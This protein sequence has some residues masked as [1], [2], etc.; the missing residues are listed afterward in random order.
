MSG[1][2]KE[3]TDEKPE[4][5]VPT[6]GVRPS[7]WSMV[8]AYKPDPE[9]KVVIQQCVQDAGKAAAYAAVPTLF[10]SAF[11][12]SKTSMSRLGKLLSTLTLTTAAA[13]VGASATVGNAYRRILHLPNTSRLKNELGCIV[14]EWNP[15]YADHRALKAYKAG[16]LGKK[17]SESEG[18]T[19]KE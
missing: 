1:T 15:A 13:Y 19:A 11:L 6:L 8:K 4:Q 7:V 9:E 14:F 17:H 3:P 16:E 10:V 5:V 2:A 18:G 12:T